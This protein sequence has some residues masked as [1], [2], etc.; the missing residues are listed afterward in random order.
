MCVFTLTADVV[1]FTEV[2]GITNAAAA[3]DDDDDDVED[4]DEEAEGDDDDGEGIID[5]GPYFSN[6]EVRSAAFDDELLIACIT[7]GVINT[8]SLSLLYMDE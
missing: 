4:D 6:I 2:E 7:A 5:A 3:A 1:T 8:V